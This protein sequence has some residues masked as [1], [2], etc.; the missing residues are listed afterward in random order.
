MSLSSGNVD[1]SAN[2]TQNKLTLQS[3]LRAAAENLVHY[4]EGTEEGSAKT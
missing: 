4:L 1:D 2:I 3:N